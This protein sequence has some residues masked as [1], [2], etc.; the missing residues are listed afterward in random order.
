MAEVQR[1]EDSER[2]RQEE[3]MRRI[4]EQDKY[5]QEQKAASEKIASQSFTQSMLRD[6]V[7]NV[8]NALTT[9]G[10]FYDE[11]ERE[12]EHDYL[13]FIAEDVERGINKQLCSYKI[14]DCMSYIV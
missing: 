2:R 3:K 14:V 9:N 11:I 7:P 1:L 10:Y 12:I 6:L 8:F 5:F 13:P 4:A